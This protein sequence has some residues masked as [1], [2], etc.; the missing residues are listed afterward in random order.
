MK[1]L[2]LVLASLLIGA[3]FPTAAYASAGGDL[4]ASADVY[5]SF[6]NGLSRT[7]T[8]IIRYSPTEIPLLSKVNSA[9]ASTAKAA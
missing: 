7:T 1:K 2:A 3:M 4:L 5:M 9:A 6:E 8:A